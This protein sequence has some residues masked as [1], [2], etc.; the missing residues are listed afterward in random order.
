MMPDSPP[1]PRPTTCADHT[2]GPAAY[3]AAAEWAERMAE[4]HDQRRCD[5]CGLWKI[6]VKR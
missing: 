3:V 5:E 6:W 4:T 2:Y 1:P